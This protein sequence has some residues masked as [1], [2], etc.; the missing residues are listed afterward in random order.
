MEVISVGVMY[1]AAL[2]PCVISSLIASEFAA[3]FGINPESFHVVNIPDLS[4]ITG[5]NEPSFLWKMLLLSDHAP[6]F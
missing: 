3:G 2:V 6:D 1:Y 5:I 4:V